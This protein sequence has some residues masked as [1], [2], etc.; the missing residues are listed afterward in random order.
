MSL[1]FF[2]MGLHTR[3]AVAHFLVLLRCYAPGC[4]VFYRLDMKLGSSQFLE[5]E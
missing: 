4:I 1:D 5:S 2:A 3:T